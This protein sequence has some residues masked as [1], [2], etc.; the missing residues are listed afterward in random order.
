MPSKSDPVRVSIPEA[1]RRL[2]VSDDT[3]RDRISRGELKAERLFSPGKRPLIR[4]QVSELER[5]VHPLAASG[6]G[7]RP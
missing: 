3:I 7:D 4:I 1:A 5:H 6:S 2:G